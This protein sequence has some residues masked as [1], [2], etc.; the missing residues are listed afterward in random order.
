M[1]S[2]TRETFNRALA[3]ASELGGMLLVQRDRGDGRYDV[4]GSHARAYL[5]QVTADGEYRCDCTAGSFGRPCKH[6]AAVF[7]FRAAQLAVGIAPATV[8]ES[9]ADV[10]ARL[11]DES[12]M[13]IARH[14]AEWDRPARESWLGEEAVTVAA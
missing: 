11:L 8:R 2:G 10:R 12:R 3:K 9:D 6:Q 4:T 14:G 13:N 7:M 1:T 5:V